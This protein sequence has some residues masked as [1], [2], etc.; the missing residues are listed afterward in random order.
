MRSFLSFLRVESTNT[1]LTKFAIFFAERV[2]LLGRKWLLSRGI[3]VNFVC[4]KRKIHRI[5]CRITVCLGIRRRNTVDRGSEFA[6]GKRPIWFLSL[7]NRRNPINRKGEWFRSR[8]FHRFQ[9]D[10]EFSKK[11]FIFTT[12]Q[13][14]L[15]RTK[16][17]S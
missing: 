2:L 6:A 11:K 7:W 17:N 16:K 10:S 9:K 12:C 15:I 1:T 8:G 14:N 13:N 4:L 5:I 3:G